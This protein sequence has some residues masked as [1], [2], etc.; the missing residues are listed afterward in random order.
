MKDKKK[1][2]A[3]SQKKKLKREGK[4]QNRDDE[5]DVIDEEAPGD[6][7]DFDQEGEKSAWE[8]EYAEIDVLRK[9]V[10]DEAPEVGT[11]AS[12]TTLH[13]KNMPLS[14]KSIQG[15]NDAKL[16]IATEIQAATL[17][18]AL[19]GRDILGAAKTGS[20]KTLAFVIP[21]IEKLYRERWSLDDG[22]S[23]IIITPTRE[24]ALQIFEVIR[25]VGKK[26]DLSAGLIT[27]GKKEYE[28]EQ[29]RIIKMNIL[30]ATPGRLLQHFE[31]TP[32]F[33]ASQ[34]MVLV[35]DEAD[36]ILDLGFKQQLDSILGYL[37]SSRQTM[38]FSATQTKSVK[39]LARL[40][41][42]SPEYLAVH[43]NDE[44]VTPKQLI[45]NY[46]I[47]PLPDKL[48][49]LFSFI[50][51][52]LKSKII[53]FFSTCAQVR[54]VHECF[55]GMQPGIALTALHGKI[56]QERRTHIYM[57]FMKKTAACM[58]ATDI[59]ARGL[60]FPDVD[61]VIQLDAPE[62]TAMYIHRVGRTARY[63]SAGR[64][65][66]LLLPNEEQPVVKLLTASGIPIKKLTINTNR[67]VSV[68]L[69]AAAL[70]VSQPENRLLAKKAFIGYLRSLQLMPTK[71]CLDLKSL[72]IDQF[73]TS[74][75]LAF[76][77]ELP[78]GLLTTSNIDTSREE[79]RERKNVNRTLDKLKKQIKEAKEEKKRAKQAAKDAALGIKPDDE[80]INKQS[81]KKSKKEE[82]SD[83]EDD[84][85][86]VKTVHDWANVDDDEDEK[87]I[88]P[89]KIVPASRKAAKE[90]K[91]KIR[92]A[93][94]GA[95]NHTLFDDNGDGRAAIRL[96]DRSKET[97]ENRR[98][99]DK[100]DVDDHIQKIKARIDSSR[101]E[102][103]ALDR[104]RIKD[105]HKEQKNRL[106]RVR[107]EDND[108][109]VQI[110]GN[111]DSSSS[112]S[113]S[114]DDDDDDDDDGDDDNYDE[115]TMKKHE[116]MALKM[117]K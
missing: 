90:K 54:F 56:K 32:G 102:D 35:L 59:A 38:L 80:N 86:T 22:L 92:T 13:F 114:A 85:L 50:K 46:V 53:V 20:G 43:A 26:H 21:L 34:L 67:T 112:S 97:G 101:A 60:D 41:L 71:Y 12:T 61:W 82:S 62:D 110:G 104:T 113:S 95:H 28:G 3:Q 58:F 33:N 81:K 64:A 75:G 7:K 5:D 69:R 73:A 17:P 44:E 89:S 48:D 105:I 74:L 115:E 40:S 70:L 6:G 10:L 36:R 45:Q 31:E 96:M 14:N 78:V 15:L 42:N 88:D 66:L 4:Y 84:L 116:E 100:K 91:L 103:V 16:T 51:T 77:P 68:S 83:D 117:L 49:I 111:S 107:D 108:E 39:D 99:V 19:S 52:H 8:E 94:I 25:I 76:T 24:L 23:A 18:H 37:P 1:S 57:D 9:R 11:Q 93:E 55:R 98:Q 29:Q 27:G 65:L 106:K 109:G 72:P 2:Y 47:S 87:V 79:N 63:N 30:V